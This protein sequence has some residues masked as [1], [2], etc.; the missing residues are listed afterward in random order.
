MQCI[1]SVFHYI[2]CSYVVYCNELKYISVDCSVRHEQV[3]GGG[4]LGWS[5]K[6]NDWRTI[7]KFPANLTYYDDDDDDDDDDDYDD[8]DDDDGDDDDDDDDDYDDDDDDDDDDVSVARWERG[9]QG[10]DDDPDWWIHPLLPHA[11]RAQC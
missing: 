2:V 8:D 6:S 7:S 11:H 3:G 10:F 4:W 1:S 5:C 9:L